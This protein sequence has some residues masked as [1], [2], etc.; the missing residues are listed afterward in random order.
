MNELSRRIIFSS[1]VLSLG[2]ALIFLAAFLLRSLAKTWVLLILSLI[3]W[4]TIALV[5]KH[6]GAK[7]D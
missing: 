6:A 5:I 7:P 3:G 1:L 2:I 4:V